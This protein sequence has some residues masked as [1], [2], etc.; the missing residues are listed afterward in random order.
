MLQRYM[1]LGGP[2]MWPLW[3][4]SLVLVGV[5]LE[6]LWS[7]GVRAKL[8]GRPTPRERLTWHRRGLAFFTDVPPSL[9]LLGTV[10]GVV[11]SFNL[12]NGRID[13]QTMAAGLGVACMTTVFGLIIAIVA[14]VS[15]YGLD[16][17][18]GPDP[19]PSQPAAVPASSV[20]PAAVA[21]AKPNPTA[22]KGGAA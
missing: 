3:L 10:L 20:K 19:E 16:W 1:E 22:A 13:S 2:L 14:T 9:G 18:I 21:E 4:C 11:Q 12:V 17:L 7:V 5:L 8:L 6:R 15:R